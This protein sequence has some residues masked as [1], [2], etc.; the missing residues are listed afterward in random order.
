MQGWLAHPM[1]QSELKQIPVAVGVSQ[2]WHHL[3]AL[4]FLRVC[5]LPFVQSRDEQRRFT[6][7]RGVVLCLLRSAAHRDL[8]P[9]LLT[10]KHKSVCNECAMA[11]STLSALTS[12]VFKLSISHLLFLLTIYSHL[13]LGQSCVLRFFQQGN[14]NHNCRLEHIFQP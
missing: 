9:L 7:Q 6:S 2:P 3:S 12:L 4:L 11:L 8:F 14:T 5:Q 10:C 1:I 13:C